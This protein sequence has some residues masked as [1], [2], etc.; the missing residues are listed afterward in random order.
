MTS[1]A[2]TWTRSLNIFLKASSAP[3][4]TSFSPVLVFIWQI[5][6]AAELALKTMIYRELSIPFKLDIFEAFF[7]AKLRRSF[8]CTGC[9]MA[10]R[11]S[12]SRS[13]PARNSA[14]RANAWPCNH[15]VHAERNAMESATDNVITWCHSNG[16]RWPAHVSSAAL[17]VHADAS[18][19]CPAAIPTTRSS[20][21]HTGR[22]L[23]SHWV[24]AAMGAP[25]TFQPL[26]LY[27]YFLLSY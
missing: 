15:A 17:F 12:T 3:L 27:L 14:Q 13:V 5:C 4:M 16:T 7:F 2:A 18:C 10:L 9:E 26:D 8:L 21:S 20:C 22:P 23:S 1:L 24:A 25:P 19:A 6:G 11:K